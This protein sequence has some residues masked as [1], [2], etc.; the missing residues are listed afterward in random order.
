MVKIKIGDKEIEG[1]GSW[2]FGDDIKEFEFEG[3]G[4]IEFSGMFDPP[5]PFVQLK[6]GD[7]VDMK[8]EKGEF[9]SKAKCT[10]KDN[11]SA[12]FIL[13]NGGYCEL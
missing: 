3:E 10:R 4:T 7:V 9:I 2:D 12:D 5:D 8:D 11:V 6:E 1:I 13:I